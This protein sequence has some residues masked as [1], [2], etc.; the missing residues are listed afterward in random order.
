[1]AAL[2][3][4]GGELKKQAAKLAGVSGL[5]ADRDLD[6]EAVGG[7]L[8]Y[9]RSS[10]PK[11]R[12]LVEIL[13]FSGIPKFKKEEWDWRAKRTARQLDPD[14]AALHSISLSAAMHMQYKRNLQRYE[15]EYFSSLIS[16]EDRTTWLKR[17]G[18]DWL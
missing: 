16:E 13:K 9:E 12:A 7:L 18:I 6:R 1:M 11:G 17:L 10:G 5:I 15:S 4:A 2:P 3:L 14:I 8:G